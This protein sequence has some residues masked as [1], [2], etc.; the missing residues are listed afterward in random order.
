MK[1]I[2][3]ILLSLGLFSS[4]ICAEEEKSFLLTKDP[5][6]MKIR[7]YFEEMK[8]ENIKFAED[9]YSEKVKVSIND[10]DILGKKN[11][12]PRLKTIH[13]SLFKEVNFDNLH[14]HTNYFSP[15]ALT[16]DGK[17]MGEV[18][19]NEK[20]IWTNVWGTVTGVGRTTNKKISFR[21]HMDFRTLDGKVVE[22][23]AFYDPAQ[24][25]AEIEALEASKTK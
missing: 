13:K 25:N 17:T 19:L 8:K 1:K 22:M 3:L 11:Y 9:F 2:T 10:L 23:L 20:T 18:N 6:S 7:K 21:M 16:S 4:I 12:L 15:E 14:V 24:M 5:I